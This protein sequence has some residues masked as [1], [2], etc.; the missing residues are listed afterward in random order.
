MTVFGAKRTVATVRSRAK[1]QTG[2]RKKRNP[3]LDFHPLRIGEGVIDLDSKISNCAFQ[4]CMA[5]QELDRAQ[6]ATLLVDLGRFFPPDRMRAKQC[7]VQS[8]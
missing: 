5:Q 6:I 4:L 7:G 8:C 2:E 1:L 3:L